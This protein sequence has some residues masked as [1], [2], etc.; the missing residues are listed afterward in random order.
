MRG[1]L[2]IL[3]VFSLAGCKEVEISERSMLVNTEHE[4]LYQLALH[5]G[6]SEASLKAK[7]NCSQ[8]ELEKSLSRLESEDSI[9]KHTAT[10]GRLVWR[11]SKDYEN[12]NEQWLS[13]IQTFSL[14]KLSSLAPN[15][16]VAQMHAEG[17][18]I[19]G[20]AFI[21]PKAEFSIIYFG[22]VGSHITPDALE[23]ANM[24]TDTTHNFYMFE[25]PSVNALTEQS[26]ISV[27]QSA[28]FNFAKEVINRVEVQ[29]TRVIGYGFSMGGF[30]VTQLSQNMVFDGLILEATATNI[31]DWVALNIPW[32]VQPFL[33]VKIQPNLLALSNAEIL[34]KTTAPVLILVGEQDQV[35][36][37]ELSQA[38]YDA[39]KHRS[40][41]Q[42]SVIPDSDHGDAALHHSFKPMLRRFLDN[43]IIH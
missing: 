26:L 16:S 25:Y 17:G 29:Q 3:L 2:L 4:V 35:T 10:D 14:S 39:A 15:H 1:L 24:F 28:A 37:V 32:Y 30:V 13:D 7:L 5:D 27:Y 19:I 9:V 18:E 11:L 21:H 20:M 12:T 22:G 38:L 42:F 6:L 41:K 23:L 43:L 34:S 36:P 8:G 40:I 31:E 33:E